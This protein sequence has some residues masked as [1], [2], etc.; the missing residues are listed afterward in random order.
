MKMNLKP[1]ILIFCSVLFLLTSC[2]KKKEPNV[3][4]VDKP[5]KEQSKGP[6]QMKNIAGQRSP[7]EWLGKTYYVVINRTSDK[8]LA[9]SKDENEHAYYDNKITVKISREDG[10]D[11]F[12]RT[13]T[14]SD[15][16]DYLDDNTRQNGALLG[17]ALNKADG[18][19][20]IF[21]A[22]VGSPDE[23]SDLYVPLVLTVSRMGAISIK[24]D[25]QLDISGEEDEEE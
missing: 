21:A 6:Q 18:D 17:I 22:S 1:I 2:G 14:K 10:S 16:G 12:E 5:I 23:L 8:S 24:R 11:F 13:F 19:N 7:V 15:F 20:L 3:I 9:M 4:I 25:V